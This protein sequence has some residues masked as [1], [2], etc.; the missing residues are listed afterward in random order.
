LTLVNRP[1]VSQIEGESSCKPK[2]STTPGVTGLP[3]VDS[4]Q[5]QGALVG[6]PVLL[7]L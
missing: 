3:V 7:A 5:T 1:L 4:G 2:F 6:A